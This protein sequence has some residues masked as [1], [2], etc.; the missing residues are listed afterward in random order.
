MVAIG[1]SILA[2][3]ERVLLLRRQTGFPV[4]DF[5]VKVVGKSIAAAA[6]SAVLPFFLTFFMPDSA[7][8]FIAVCALSVSALALSVWFVGLDSS[9]RDYVSSAFLRKVASLRGIFS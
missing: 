8:R 5:S 9:E 6:I 2:M 3:F 4:L 7:F 1:I